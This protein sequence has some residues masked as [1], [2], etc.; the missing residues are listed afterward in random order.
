MRRRRQKREEDCDGVAAATPRSESRFITPGPALDGRR[1]QQQS[2]FTRRMTIGR[3]SPILWDA[4]V[5]YWELHIMGLSSRRDRDHALLLHVQH[6]ASDDLT[7]LHAFEHPERE[8]K[9]DQRPHNS[10][11]DEKPTYSDNAANG[12]ISR[13]HFTLPKAAISSASRASCRFLGP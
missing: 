12:L 2:D 5:Q 10:K 11:K 8:A 13:W 7:L 9:G 6:D 4:K 3:F 1:S